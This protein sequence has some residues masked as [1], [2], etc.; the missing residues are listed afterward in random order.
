MV[1]LTS[2]GGVHTIQSPFAAPAE[3]LQIQQEPPAGGNTVQ[4]V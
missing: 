1:T 3:T 2:E 4:W